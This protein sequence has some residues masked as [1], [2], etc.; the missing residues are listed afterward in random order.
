MFIYRKFKNRNFFFWNFT[1]R[2]SSQANLFQYSSLWR[3][4]LF[5]DITQRRLV[6]TFRNNLSVPSSRVKQSIRCPCTSQISFTCYPPPTKR[7]LFPN[8]L[9]VKQQRSLSEC[10]LESSPS[11]THLEVGVPSATLTDPEA[12]LR[13]CEIS[14]QRPDDPPVQRVTVHQKLHLSATHGHRNFVPCAVGQAEWERLHLCCHFVL[15]LIM[16]PDFIL[17]AT[18]LQFQV[19]VKENACSLSLLFMSNF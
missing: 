12:Q 15:Y 13:H 14:V 7:S 6:V 4:S 16:K 8:M 19:P 18:G 10:Y 17:T 2:L 9:L 5:W 3:P 1:I 11:E